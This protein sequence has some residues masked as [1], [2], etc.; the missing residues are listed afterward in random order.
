SYYLG[1]YGHT[2][3]T[4]GSVFWTKFNQ[5]FHQLFPNEEK[6]VAEIEKSIYNVI[7]A[8]QTND[9]NI[10]YHAVMEG[11]RERPSGGHNSC[12]EG[13]GTRALGTLPEYIY[14]IAPDG[15]YVN[16]YEPS[17]INCTVN[18]QA[19]GLTI[20][21]EFPFKPQVAVKVKT[22]SA[23][24]INLRIRIPSWATEKMAIYVNDKKFVTGKPGT[25]AELSRKW[26]DGDVISF[27]LPMGLHLNRYTGVNKVEGAE[28][29][30]AEYGP[31]L[32]AVIGSE[33]TPAHIK[34]DPSKPQNY[35]KQTE[36]LKFN[37]T[38][39]LSFV[40]Y[41]QVPEQQKFTIYPVVEK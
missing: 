8:C 3:E 12:C 4:C 11:E 18:G 21:S 40:P 13:Q 17:S 20:E 22:S 9:G 25:Y 39:S 29:Y 27:T 35:L 41:W 19:V 5:R 26:D 1:G 6:Y 14:S 38:D 36:S 37:V 15:L 24:K 33:K 2:G 23:E 28:R 10:R 31:V 30:A 16:L 34:I 32:L 7:L